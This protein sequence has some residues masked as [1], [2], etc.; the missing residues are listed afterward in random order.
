MTGVQT[1]ALPISL[2]DIARMVDP[3]EEEGDAVLP[4]LL[5]RGQPM[6]GLLETRAEL[7][8]QLLHIVTPRLHRPGEDSIGHHYRRS[9]E[10]TSELQT[11]MSTS[12]AGFCLKTKKQK[13]T[14]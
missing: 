2:A 13:T 1:C 8:G 12:Y 6:R 3:Q 11:L 4:R 14:Q 7:P 9:E 5:Q 10:H